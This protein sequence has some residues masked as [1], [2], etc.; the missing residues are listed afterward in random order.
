[1]TADK[2]LSDDKRNAFSC[3][4]DKAPDVLTDLC[5]CMTLYVHVRV[6]CRSVSGVYVIIHSMY[7]YVCVCVTTGMTNC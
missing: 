2:T 4:W 6:A 3:F 5:M 1:M 7:V